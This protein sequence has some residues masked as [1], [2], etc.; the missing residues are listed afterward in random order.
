M[1]LDDWMA[2]LSEEIGTDDLQFDDD[3]VHTLLDLARDAAHEV[4]R[5][6]APLT[7][8]LVGVAVGRG[9]PLGEAAAKA[10]ALAM[11]HPEQTG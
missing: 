11:K 9:V 3:A 1:S 7:T 2:A 5:V 8:F 6:A 4:E 10:T